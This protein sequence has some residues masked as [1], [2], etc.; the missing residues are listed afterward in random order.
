MLKDRVF[1]LKVLSEYVVEFKRLVSGTERISKVAFDSVGA[2]IFTLW[3]M[4][5]LEK[6]CLRLKVLVQLS[7]WISAK[8]NKKLNCGG[9]EV[10]YIEINNVLL[11]WRMMLQQSLKIL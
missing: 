2:I 8:M 6:S 10:D 4:G 7:S 3:E 1:G 9:I 5:S 11:L